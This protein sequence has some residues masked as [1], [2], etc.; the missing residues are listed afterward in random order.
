MPWYPGSQ[1]E[2]IPFPETI[3]PGVSHKEFLHLGL[4]ELLATLVSYVSTAGTLVPQPKLLVR[5]VPVCLSF[6]HAC[7]APCQSSPVTSA[8]PYPGPEGYQPPLPPKWLLTHSIPQVLLRLRPCSGSSPLCCLRAPCLIPTSLA[9]Q[10]LHGLL[11][12]RQREDRGR[13]PFFA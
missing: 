8:E 12:R 2:T 1:C 11:R 7:P 13:F 3:S 5:T 9:P 4:S 10:F 6:P